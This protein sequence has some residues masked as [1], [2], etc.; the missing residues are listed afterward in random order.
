MKREFHRPDCETFFP[1]RYR[2]LY[3]GEDFFF[4]FV[5]T[6]TDFIGKIPFSMEGGFSRPI[7]VSLLSLKG[8]REGQVNKSGQGEKFRG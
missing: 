1:Y 5:L 8:R 2:I 3:R 4:C 7:L 6:F